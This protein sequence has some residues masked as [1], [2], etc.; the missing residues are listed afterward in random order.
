MAF[1]ELRDNVDD[2]QQ[3][4][5]AY[6][7][8]NIEYYKLLGF[9]IVAKT[10]IMFVKYSLILLSFAFVLLFGSIAAGF[11]IGSVLENTALGFLIIAGAYL[12]IGLIFL[13][14]NYKAVEK[15]ILKRF[16]DMF[17]KD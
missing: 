12:V 14:L 2:L 15:P 10:T 9:K 1:S 5:K 4:T 6:I 11:A 3:D 7:D 8:K 16:S 13:L 17:F